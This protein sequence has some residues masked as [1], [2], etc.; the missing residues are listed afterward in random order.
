MNS[1][2][3]CLDKAA[4]E[5]LAILALALPVG[6]QAQTPQ[7]QSLTGANGGGTSTA[8]I[9]T[10]T[11]TI[12]QPNVARLHSRDFTLDGG[13]WSIIAAIQ[14]PGAP[15]LAVRQTETN[16]VVVSWSI[17]WPGFYLEETPDPIHPT[18]TKVAVEPI[19]LVVAKDKTEKQ[20]VLPRPEGNRFF[21]LKNE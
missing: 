2:P 6:L 4:G 18:W 15:T 5:L 21:H 14:E 8:G 12:G 19:E 17:A 16:T 1:Q 3:S 9:Y 7:L 20:V 10:L 11:G 13:S